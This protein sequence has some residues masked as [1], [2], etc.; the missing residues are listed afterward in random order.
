MIVDKR[1]D[2]LEDLLEYTQAVITRE[3]VDLDQ[4]GN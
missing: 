1:R 2:V 4:D 3:L